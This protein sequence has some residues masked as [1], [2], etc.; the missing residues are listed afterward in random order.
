LLNYTIKGVQK[1]RIAT[2]LTDKIKRAKPKEKMYK[3]FDGDGLYLEV[4]PTD[5]KVWRIKYRLFGKKRTCTVVD[6]L[7]VTLSQA[8]AITR[9]VKQKVLDG[10]DLVA[11]RQAKKELKEEKLFKN[12][13][14]DFLNKKQ[15][16]L[17]KYILKTKRQD[18]ELYITRFMG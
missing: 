4:K 16:K 6:Y 8:R 7:T 17:V 1:I 13:I 9:E 11:E 18:R 2:P 10:I 3:L 12:I 5:R 15:K 14:A